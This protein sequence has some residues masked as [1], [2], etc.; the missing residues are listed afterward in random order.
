VTEL[1]SLSDLSWNF[2]YRNQT[3]KQWFSYCCAGVSAGNEVVVSVTTLF[4]CSQCSSTG[5][6]QSSSQTTI[7]CHHCHSR[8]DS[9]RKL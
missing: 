8:T 5:R 6:Q 4:Y 1:E 3:H 9:G 7:R 2:S